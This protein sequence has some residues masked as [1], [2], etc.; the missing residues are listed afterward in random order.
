VTE[1][2]PSDANW[3]ESPLENPLPCGVAAFPPACPFVD[4]TKADLVKTGLIAA[5]MNG[6]VG[7][8]E[9]SNHYRNDGLLLLIH[10]LSGTDS[11]SRDTSEIS[12]RGTKRSDMTL[13]FHNVPLVIVEE[14]HDK[15]SGAVAD[16]KSK[17]H[18][19]PHYEDVP[20]VFAIAISVAQFQVYLMT[21]DEGWKSKPPLVNE[22]ISD[23][24]GRAQCL[25]HAVNIAR[26]IKFFI[27]REMVCPSEVPFN[28]WV[29]RTSKKIRLLPA[30]SCVEVRYDADKEKYE[31]LKKLYAL[32]VERGVRHIEKMNSFDDATRTFQLEP[33]GVRRQPNSIEELRRALR[34]VL[35]CIRD[36]HEAGYA[37]C[38]IRWPNIIK[39]GGAWYVIDCTE[40]IALAAKEKYRLAVSRCI[41]NKNVFDTDLPWSTRHDYYQFGR[42]ILTSGRV[43]PADWKKIA[44]MLYDKKRLA[45]SEEEIKE[46]ACCLQGKK[47]RKRD[48][49]A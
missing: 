24:T 46:I 3:L 36:L 33:Y 42:L 34:H 28:I 11:Y 32:L 25:V 31:A 29:E 21:E 9:N 23:I 6:I 7:I 18:W 41:N 2:D 20:F 12:T 44:D 49:E 22:N 43:I 27:E 47:K 13:M 48:E 35:K 19:L 30:L 39:S 26:V 38:D 8:G 10:F 15:V 17:A 40:S 1:L 5:W 37:H 16:I 4:V 14:K 45:I